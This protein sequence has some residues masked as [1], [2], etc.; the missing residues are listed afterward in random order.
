MRRWIGGT[1]L[2]GTALLAAGLG[3][4]LVLDRLYPPDFSRLAVA[5]TEV[6]DREGR[7]VGMVPAPGGVWRLRT[8][9]R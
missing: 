3:G 8:T 5:G 9:G 4:F 6:L 2:A 1:L 7:T